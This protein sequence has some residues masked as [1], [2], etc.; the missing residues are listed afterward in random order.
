MVPFCNDKDCDIAPLGKHGHSKNGDIYFDWA[1]FQ[2]KKCSGYAVV[3]NTTVHVEDP[4]TKYMNVRCINCGHK[5]FKKLCA[6]LLLMGKSS[7]SN[8]AAFL[9]NIRKLSIGPR[10]RNPSFM[11]RS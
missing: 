6:I 5:L 4:E 1:R 8:T 3:C 10:K 9:R 2:C 7:G 11:K